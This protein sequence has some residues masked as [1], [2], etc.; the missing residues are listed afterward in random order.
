MKLQASV[1]FGEGQ[2]AKLQVKSYKVIKFND[3]ELYEFY[4]FTNF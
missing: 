4:N 3:I 1:Q 2:H